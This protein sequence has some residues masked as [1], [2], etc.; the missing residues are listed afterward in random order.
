MAGDY[1][2]A[3]NQEVVREPDQPPPEV[4]PDPEAD[5]EPDAD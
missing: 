2:D 5:P 1:Y 3:P 4:D